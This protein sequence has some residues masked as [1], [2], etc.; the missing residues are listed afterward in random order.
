MF[1]LLCLGHTQKCWGGW[2]E[3]GG[4][5]VLG[6]NPGPHTSKTCALPFELGYFFELLKI[7]LI[8]IINNIFLFIYFSPPQ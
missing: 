3:V 5:E 2:G 7:I 6:L 8:I 1:F 4:S